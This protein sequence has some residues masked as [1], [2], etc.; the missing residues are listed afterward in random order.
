MNKKMIKVLFTAILGIVISSGISA[1]AQSGSS[2]RENPQRISSRTVTANVS[3]ELGDYHETFYSIAAGRGNISVDLSAVAQNG[4]NISVG[5]EG[6]GVSK[7]LGPLASGG[8]D[9]MSDRI[10]FNNPTRQNLLIT[11][12]SSGNAKYTLKFAGA[13]LDQKDETSDTEK[14]AVRSVTKTVSSE[15]GDYREVH[16]SLVANRGYVTID[17]EAIAREGMNITL[18][19]EG[20]NVNESIGPLATGGDDTMNGNVRFYVRSRQTLKITVVYSGNA[21][22]TINAGGSVVSLTER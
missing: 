22:Y 2:D 13:V 10:S 17:F 7:S 16:Y 4:M 9:R 3:S 1:M 21:K 20:T 11:V 8:N 5:I 15:L 19:I 14:S 18:G 12:S 6:D